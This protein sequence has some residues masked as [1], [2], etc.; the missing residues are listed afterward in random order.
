MS[1]FYPLLIGA[2]AIAVTIFV[3]AYIVTS[4]FI[5]LPL[6]GLITFYVWRSYKKRRV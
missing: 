2:A 6:L 4:P 1:D 3:F 5:I